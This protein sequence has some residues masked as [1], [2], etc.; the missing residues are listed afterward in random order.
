MFPKL[1]SMN[2]FGSFGLL[3]SLARF[4]HSKSTSCRCE[5]QVNDE[6]MAPSFPWR[7][8]AGSSSGIAS[9]TF[10]GL[11]LGLIA[12]LYIPVESGPQG[13]GMKSS[14]GHMKL[15]TFTDF[16]FI[17]DKHLKPNSLYSYVLLFIEKQ[18]V[19]AYIS[20]SQL[21]CTCALQLCVLFFSFFRY[22]G[23][24]LVIIQISNWITI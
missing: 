4:L 3:R 14:A 18:I 24:I 20:A 6:M 1:V 21:C 17:C 22:S 5:D 13:L 19:I 16:W 10:L 12:L 7:S 9:Q 11:A 8:N 23:V 2:S 15:V